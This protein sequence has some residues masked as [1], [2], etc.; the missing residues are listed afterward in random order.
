MPYTRHPVPMT[1]PNFEEL[2]AR[3]S[4]LIQQLMN[5]MQDG[6]RCTHLTVRTPYLPCPDPAC[7]AMPPGCRNVFYYARPGP[8]IP[9]GAFSETELAT[10]YA[11][12]TVETWRRH[13]MRLDG[14]EEVWGWERE[15]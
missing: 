15:R 10:Y 6:A 1:Q 13:R 8:T 11:S 2:E 9:L 4:Q 12:V 5:L 14:M 7:Y 3:N